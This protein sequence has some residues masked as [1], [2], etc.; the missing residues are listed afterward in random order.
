MMAN[1]RFKRARSSRVACFDTEIGP[2][3]GPASESRPHL[4]FLTSPHLA[5]PT[6]GHV[7][8]VAQMVRTNLLSKYKIQRAGMIVLVCRR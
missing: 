1:R 5:N 8:T 6:G 4:R 7:W 3:I 2:L